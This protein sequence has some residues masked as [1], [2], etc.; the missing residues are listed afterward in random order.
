MAVTSPAS[1]KKLLH[2][3]R[4]VLASK[5]EGAQRTWLEGPHD[6]GRP[7]ALAPGC[8]PA[9]EKKHPPPGKSAEWEQEC[10]S[11]WPWSQCLRCSL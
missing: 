11:G 9:V 8:L 1:P 7:S 10:Q 3:H 4:I 6:P 5:A 2:S